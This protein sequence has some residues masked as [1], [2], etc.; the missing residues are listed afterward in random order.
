VVPEPARRA[1]WS[2]LLAHPE[3]VERAVL[4]SRVGIMAFHGG[5]EG[6]T[7]E[8]AAAA[9]DASGA[10]L[11]TVEQPAGLRWHVPSNAVDPAVAPPLATWLL[12][13]DV[14]IA[15]HG[16]GRIAR[17]RQVL[18]GGTNRQLAAVLSDELEARLSGFAVV[19][20]L[21]LIPVELRGLHPANPVNRPPDGGVQLELPP[22]ARGT[23][24]GSDRNRG[25]VVEALV[26][27]VR[28]WE[29]RQ[30]PAPS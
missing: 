11:Y 4:R 16:Y 24:P 8:I 14:A 26:A 5:L 10:S 30:S 21:Q 27:A 25:L 23:S 2:D 17:P 22:S 3:V 19:S 18:V 9:A 1:T 12:H 13:V 29:P 6:G 28:E 20:D 7:L 15:L